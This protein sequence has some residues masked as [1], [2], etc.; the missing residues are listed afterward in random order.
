MKQALIHLTFFSLCFAICLSKPLY[1][2]FRFSQISVQGNSNTDVETIKSISGLKRNISLSSNDLNLALKNLYNSNLFENVQVIPKGQ[3]ILIKVKENKRIRRLVF[4]GNKK[5][6]EKELLPLIKSK[7][8]QP[9]SK[10]QVVKDSRII[11]DFYRF[12][13]RYSA[14]VEPKIIERDKGFV[15]LVF[16]IDEGSILQISQI[17]FAGNKAFSDRQLRDVIRSKTAGLFSSFFTSDNYSEDSQKAD[18][19]LLEK[20]YRDQGFPDAKVIASLGG[21]KNSGVSAFLTYSI[22]EGPSFK[23]GDVSIKSMVKGISSSIYEK[24]VVV[25]KGGNFNSSK[26]Q[27]TLDNIKKVSVSNGY[28]F[29][30]GKVDKVRNFKD[31]EISLLFKI[32]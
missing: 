27:E 7:E 24:S 22:Y 20:F 2:Q 29:L 17:N 4:E 10:A 31:K 21:L 9:F 26:I 8:R 1:P 3:T 18:K 6:E 15:D 13:S 12:K 28:P 32:I 23:F 11:S 30:I 14:R 5:I 16:E 25:S 19:Y